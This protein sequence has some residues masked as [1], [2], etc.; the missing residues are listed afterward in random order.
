[1]S[2]FSK[3]D[4][5]SLKQVLAAL[6]PKEREAL[7]RFYLLDHDADRIQ[8]ELGVDAQQ[9]SEIKSRVKAFCLSNRMQ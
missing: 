5:A 7:L 6:S 3:M 2:T 4:D 1:M 9:L 8:S